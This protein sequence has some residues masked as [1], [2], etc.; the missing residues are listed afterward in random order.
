[1]VGFGVGFGVD[2]FVS[3]FVLAVS[4]GVGAGGVSV[5]LVLAMGTVVVLSSV[6]LMAV[7]KSFCVYVLDTAILPTFHMLLESSHVSGAR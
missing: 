4:G 1:M 6:V 5:V 3:C 7:V 2:V